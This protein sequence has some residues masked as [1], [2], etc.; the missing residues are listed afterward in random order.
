LI[1][2]IN[3]ELATIATETGAELL[4]GPLRYHSESGGWQLGDLDLSEA[5]LREA[6]L[7]R[8]DLNG[9]NLFRADLTGAEV[10]DEQLAQVRSLRHATMPD[11]TKHG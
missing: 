5:T 4:R 2:H 1:L 3:H 8:A 9:A 11:G 6:K 10:K 7:C